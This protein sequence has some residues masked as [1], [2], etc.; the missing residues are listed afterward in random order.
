MD[1]IANISLVLAAL[2]RLEDH[3]MH[4][5]VEAVDDL[6]SIIRDIIATSPEPW[7][8]YRSGRMDTDM[9]AAALVLA[10]AYNLLGHGAAVDLRQDLGSTRRV[11]AYLRAARALISTDPRGETSAAGDHAN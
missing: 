5:H 3:Q 4:H 8:V 6:V 10:D 1:P 11:M 7:A 2:E 9:R